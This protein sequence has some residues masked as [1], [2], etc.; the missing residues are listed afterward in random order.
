MTMPARGRASHCGARL[1]CAAAPPGA[2][3]G[4]TQFAP[5]LAQAKP[6]HQG[7]PSSA[8]CDLG[9]AALPA[10]CA[11][12]SAPR[13]CTVGGCRWA[14][15]TRTTLRHRCPPTLP[16]CLAF[17]PWRTSHAHPGSPNKC[18]CS[19]LAQLPVLPRAGDAAPVRAPRALRRPGG[20]QRGARLPAAAGQRGL[21]RPLSAA[22][23]GPL[24]LLARSVTGASGMRAPCG[25]PLVGTRRVG[26]A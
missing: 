11:C 15:A 1:R 26:V 5:V 16:R 17:S 9:R 3:Q 25:H 19:W 13:L 6:L 4:G 8:L 22:A 20:R 2:G 24:Q 10:D 21:G 23:P 14:S 12:V 18:V 7:C